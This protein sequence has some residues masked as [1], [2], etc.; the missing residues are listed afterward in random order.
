MTYAEAV[1]HYG[2]QNKAAAALGIPRPTLQSRLQAEKLKARSADNVLTFP[3]LP[4]ARE[5]IGKLIDRRT[6]HFNRLHANRK[7]AT[8]QQI[9]VEDDGPIAIA[10]MGDPHV[11]DDGCNW[12]QLRADAETIAG[13]PGMYGLNIGD[14]TNNWVGRLARLFGNQETSQTSARQLAEWLLCGTSIK[15]LA[16]ILGNHDLWNEGAEIIK[17]MCA[18]SEAAIPVHE[19]AAKLE[20]LFP[21]KTTY[22]ISAAHDFKGR[23]IYNASHGL[24]REAIWHQ[25]GTDLFVAG[26]IHFGEIQKCELPGGKSPWLVRV[27]GY[28]DHDPHALVEGYHEGNRFRTVVVI[29]DPH[30]SED[31]RAT[32]FTDVQQA[33]KVLTL[34]RS[35][36]A[37][38][39]KPAAKSKRKQT[40][41]R[42]R[43]VPI[44][45]RVGGRN[46]KSHGR[47]K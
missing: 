47:V 40:N 37:R 22:R 12:P 46:R 44:R 29:I 41:G 1:A 2:S 13:T 23:S 39:K 18:V 28:K 36:Y 32:V 4:D 6:E 11:D 15:W 8:W 30:A 16:V 45:N 20:L 5:P 31:G 9:V 24:K 34:M 42:S 19:W 10:C 17:R 38:S 27:R 35:V 25:D 7:A 43:N 14:Q 21:N 3:S 33:A 26:H